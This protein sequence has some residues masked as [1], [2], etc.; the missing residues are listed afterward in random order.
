MSENENQ[1]RDLYGR[2]ID[3]INGRRLDELDQFTHDSLTFNGQ[4]MTRDEYRAAIEAHIGAVPDFTW[5][6]DEFVIDE[7]DVFVRLLDHGTP[8]QEWL[9]LQPSGAQIHFLEFA[10]YR[11]RDGRFDWINVVLD[12]PSIARQMAGEQASIFRPQ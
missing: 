1:I 2:Y 9:G 10:M 11:F 5:W 6:V 7:N 3:A 4:E 8:A 12:R